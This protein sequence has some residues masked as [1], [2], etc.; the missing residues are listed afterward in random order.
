VGL[1]YIE[2]YNE[3]VKDLLNP[4]AKLDVVEAYGVDIR[5]C[6]PVEVT[7]E[8]VRQTRPGRALAAPAHSSP[9]RDQALRLLAEGDARR[10]TAETQMNS[11]SS[12]SHAIVRLTISSRLSNGACAAGCAAADARALTPLPPQPVW[13]AAAGWRC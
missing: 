5:G 4:S 7:E 8:G 12:R 6:K 2:I 11:A 9:S 13:R 10:A 1:Q 3:Q